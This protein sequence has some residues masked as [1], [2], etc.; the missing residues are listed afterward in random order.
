MTT[1]STHTADAT[2]ATG[3]LAVTMSALRI[4]GYGHRPALAQVP[5][6]SA[7]PGQVLVE[8]AAAALNPLDVKLVAGH[9]ADVFPVESFPYTVGTDLSGTV[10]AVGCDVTDWKVGDQVIARTDPAAGGAVAEFAVVPQR[11]LASAPASVPLPVAAGIGTAAGTAWQALHEIADIR[12]GQTVLV[13]AAAGGVGHIAVQMAARAGARVVATTSPAGADVARRLGAHQ[14]ID[15]TST[16]FRT[17]IS[18]VDVVVDTVGQDVEAASLDVLKPG[19]LLLALP[20]PPDTDRATARG[21]RAEF[22]VHQSD[23]KRLAA[24]AAEFDAGLEL[25]VDRT[26][27]LEDAAQALDVVAAGHAKGKVLVEPAG[28]T[29]PA[30]PLP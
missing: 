21:R 4:D 14:I 24:V 13:H 28:T 7:G 10:A 18:D 2:G 17:E 8:I 20:V 9:L 3:A 26:L 25:L 27:P 15:Y 29:S 16:D 12:P 11:H 1:S 30:S 19:G 23:G 5:T 6:P 22:V